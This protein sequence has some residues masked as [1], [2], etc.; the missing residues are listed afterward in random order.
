MNRKRAIIVAVA[1]VLV[2]LAALY[3]WGPSSVPAGQEP[4]IKLSGAN[5]DNFEA[6]FDGGASVPRLLLLLSPT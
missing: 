3:L 6:A 2:L 4:L 5:F 1:A